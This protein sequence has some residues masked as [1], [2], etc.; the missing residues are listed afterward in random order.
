M[1]NQLNCIFKKIKFTKMLFVELIT[2]I[3]LIICGF[4]VKINPNLIAG[5]SSMSDDEKK[6]ID[7]TKISLFMY[8]GLITTG[9]V[10]IFIGIFLGTFNL[11]DQYRIMITVMITTLSVIY[12]TIYSTKKS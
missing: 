2:G 4:L 11:K 9:V 1:Y 12:I 8:K 6:K 5:Y 7:I 3:I 10:I